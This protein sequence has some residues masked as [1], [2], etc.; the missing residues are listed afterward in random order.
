MSILLILH[1]SCA[2]LGTA[3]ETSHEYKYFI[4][5]PKTK[6]DVNVHLSSLH[7]FERFFILFMTF[8][9]AFSFSYYTANHMCLRLF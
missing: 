9:A 2:S 1:P 3:P 8:K 7:N 4:L 5:V 6:V